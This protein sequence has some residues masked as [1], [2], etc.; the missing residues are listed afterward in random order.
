MDTLKVLAVLLLLQEV[1]T[2]RQ[3][4]LRPC[5]CLWQ[6]DPYKSS[7]PVKSAVCQGFCLVIFLLI[8]HP[9]HRFEGC[10]KCDAGDAV[11]VRW[12]DA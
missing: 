8:L 9:I 7:A 3:H 2:R 4:P 1:S 10:L 6:L 11:L 12:G 5:S